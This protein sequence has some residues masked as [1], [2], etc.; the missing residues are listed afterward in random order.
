[1]EESIEQLR[2]KSRASAAR[3]TK[4]VK[5]E[6]EAHRNMAAGDQMAR[7]AHSR[8]LRELDAADAAARKDGAALDEAEKK[9]KAK[10]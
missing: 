10:K 7:V 2:E 3:F 6:E 9:A 4:A 5:S 1:M 8:A